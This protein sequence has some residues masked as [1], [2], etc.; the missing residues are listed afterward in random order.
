MKDSDRLIPKITEPK[1]AKHHKPRSAFSFSSV[2]KARGFFSKEKEKSRKE[3]PEPLCT[4]F[5]DIIILSI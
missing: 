3:A 1:G 4:Y 5:E 2:G